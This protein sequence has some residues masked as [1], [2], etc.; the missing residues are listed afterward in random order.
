MPTIQW[1]PREYVILNYPKA[2]TRLGAYTL[3]SPTIKMRAKI[4][5]NKMLVASS[6]FLHTTL[7]TFVQH[8]KSG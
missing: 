1:L 7:R 2:S 8:S 4:G 5:T 6:V 3:A